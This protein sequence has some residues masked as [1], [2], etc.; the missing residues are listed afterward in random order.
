MI[1]FIKLIENIGFKPIVKNLRYYYNHW[2]IDVVVVE[3]ISHDS[4][5]SKDPIWHLTYKDGNPDPL[6]KVEVIHNFIKIEDHSLIK[7]YFKKELRDIKLKD[8][9]II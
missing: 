9:G 5:L 8:L 4:R 3:T 6:N 1:E 7:K 2:R